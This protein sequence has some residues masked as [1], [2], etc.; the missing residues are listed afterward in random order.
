VKFT[1][2]LIIIS[3]RNCKHILYTMSEPKHFLLSGYPQELIVHHQKYWP[4]GP[5][6]E[7]LTQWS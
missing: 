6:S 5:S 4:S 3:L 2:A 7:V 1:S